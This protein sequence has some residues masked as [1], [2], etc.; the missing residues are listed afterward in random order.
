[1]Q[2]QR[3]YEDDATV[4]AQWMSNL[5]ITATLWN[6]PLRPTHAEL[7]REFLLKSD[8]TSMS[9]AIRLLN[10]KTLI[11]Y[12]GF[13]SID[14]RNRLGEVSIV[15][16]ELENHRKG[17]G[18]EALSILIEYGFQELNLNRIELTV[19]SFNR[20]AIRLYQ[21]LGFQQE[22]VLRQSLFR[23]GRYHDVWVMVLLRD[24]WTRLSS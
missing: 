6:A 23:D 1:M 17:F 10:N 22:G 3:I 11:G 16:G 5:D 8:G 4:S 12:I 2:G 15:I 7:E 21:K 13:K 9:F 14:H 20:V 19:L 24:E 18:T